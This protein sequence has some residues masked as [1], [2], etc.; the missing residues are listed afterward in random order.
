MMF[1][2]HI[3]FLP[4]FA[5]LISLY[6]GRFDP[7]N[8]VLIKETVYRLLTLNFIFMPLFWPASFVLI[9][10]IKGAGDVR[11]TTVVSISTMWLVR[12]LFAYILGSVFGLGVTGVWL[13]MFSDWAVRSVFAVIRFRGKKWQEKSLI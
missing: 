10:G 11:F 8:L 4:L 3:L 7:H 13:G 9:A 5:P 1:L 12:V 6:T 2:T